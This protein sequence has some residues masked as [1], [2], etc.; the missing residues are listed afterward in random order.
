MNIFVLHENPTIAAQYHCDRHVVKMVLETAQLLS[1][2]HHI[3]SSPLASQVYRPTHKNHPSN[4][5]VRESLENHLWA[6]QLFCA[7]MDEYTFRYGKTHAC[8]RLLPIFLDKALFTLDWPSEGLTPFAQ[9]MPD[10]CKNEN[11]VVAYRTY[12]AE[13]KHRMLKYTRRPRPA[14]LLNI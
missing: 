1:T 7:L 14:W 11:A 12:Y 6:I 10:E 13:H 3:L 9:A 8:A 4:V 2:T 5:W